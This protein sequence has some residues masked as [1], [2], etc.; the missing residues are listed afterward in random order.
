MTDK[1]AYIDYK[2]RVIA[3]FL[4]SKEDDEPSSS[5]ERDCKACIL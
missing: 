4:Q 5:K 1:R 3:S 2:N